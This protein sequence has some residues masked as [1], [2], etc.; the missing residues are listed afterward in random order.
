MSTAT[1]KSSFA[2]YIHFIIIAFFAFGFGLIPPVEPITQ[3]GMV[4]LGC[5]IGAIYGWST[6]GIIWPSIIAI[7]GMSLTL[8]MS[9]VLTAGFGSNICWMVIFTYF[10]IGLMEETKLMETIAAFL[11]T[12][13]FCQGK[14]WIQFGFILFSSQIIGTIGGFASLMLFLT[15]FFN[16]AKLLNIPPYSKFVVIS[17]FGVLFTHVFGMIAFPFLGNALIFISIWQSMGGAEID[18]V[19]YMI[20]SFSMIIVA[21]FTF[22]LVCR[23]IIRLDLSPMKNFRIEDLGIS[24]IKFT[25][26]QKYASI[27]VIWMMI[28][29][30]LPSILQLLRLLVHLHFLQNK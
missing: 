1:Q 2:Y 7:L 15:L 17:C 29:L 4:L 26:M 11:L 30:L 28:D 6:I 24:S 18:F 8:G 14:P 9:T 5:F 27:A 10:I 25:P 3:K 22:I 23:F 16:I 20:S 19:H 21:F 12:R 13:K